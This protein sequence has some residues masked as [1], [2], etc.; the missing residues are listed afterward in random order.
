MYACP[1]SRD[2]CTYE[3]IHG[4]QEE[5]AVAV[6]EPEAAAKCVEAPEVSKPRRERVQQQRA[7]VAPRG[8]GL[9]GRREQL[10]ERGHDVR[11]EEAR[12]RRVV[13]AHVDE[14]AQ[15]DVG[16]VRRVAV[17]LARRLQQHR[18]G[19]DSTL[20]ACACMVCIILLHFLRRCAT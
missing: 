2:V 5:E 9:G 20:Y 15:R 18:R 16:H 17:V 19:A 10:R 13:E 3:C 7:Q 12:V 6:P 4:A 11:L 1:P 8:R 14:R